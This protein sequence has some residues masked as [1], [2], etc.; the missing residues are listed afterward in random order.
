MNAQKKEPVLVKKIRPYPIEAKV[1]KSETT[2]PI[3]GQI[4]RITKIGF[5]MEVDKIM[6]SVG[7]TWKA[8]FTLPH[9][10]VTIT[11]PVKIVRTMDRYKDEKATTKSYLVEMHFL[12]LDPLNLKAIA[13][14]EKAINQKLTS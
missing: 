7:E 12:N 6:F 14:F 1:L 10:Q 13:E 8:V 11:E 2:P 5:Q 4:L 9:S 3:V